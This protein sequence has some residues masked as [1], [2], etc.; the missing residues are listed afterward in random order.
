MEVDSDGEAGGAEHSG[1]HKSLQ[2]HVNFSAQLQVQY[3]REVSGEFFKI[4]AFHAFLCKQAS[5]G[6]IL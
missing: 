5:C 2:E 3:A 4:Q 6:W 1:L